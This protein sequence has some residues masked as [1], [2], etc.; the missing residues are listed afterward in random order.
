VDAQAAPAQNVM[1][2]MTRENPEKA[3]AEARRLVMP[4]HHDVR[5]E[6]IDLKRLGAVLAVAYM[7]VTCAISLRGFLSRTSAPEP[8]NHLL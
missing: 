4:I 3:I 8:C 1:V 2:Q 6:D 7:N 5:A